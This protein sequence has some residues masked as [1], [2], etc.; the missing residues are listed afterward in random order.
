MAL[1]DSRDYY[2]WLIKNFVRCDS[3]PRRRQFSNVLETLY[4][5]PFEA[6][7]KRDVDRIDKGLNLRAEFARECPCDYIF[8]DE[9]PSWCS[10]LEVLCALSRDIEHIMFDEKIGDR[11]DAWFWTMF[12]NLGLTDFSNR[13]YWDVEDDLIPVLKNWMDRN[14]ES[15]GHGSIFEIERSDVDMRMVDLWH[16]ANFYIVENFNF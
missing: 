14:Y 16:Q 4:A 9:M 11:T 2:N 13:I 8:W 10:V 7:L 12:E 6:K 3:Y 1:R 5:T 15:N